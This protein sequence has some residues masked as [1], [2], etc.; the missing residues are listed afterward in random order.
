MNLSEHAICE[1]LSGRLPSGRL[2]ACFESDAE[3]IVLNGGKCLFT[4]DEF[5]EED[6]FGEGDARLLGWNIAVGAISD[7]YACGGQPL[8]YAHAL[9]VDEKWDGRYVSGF[10]E[11]VR[12]ALEATGARF[13]GGD[14]GRA[15]LWRCTVSVLGLCEGAPVLR[16]GA[17]PG[18][19]IYLTGPIGGGNLEAAL[20]LA[21]GQAG[22]GAPGPDWV[23]RL[24]VRREE[25][26]L[27]KGFASACIDTSDGVW[28]G[29]NAL[30]DL[31]GCGYALAN[32]PYLPAGLDFSAR[33]SLPRGLLFLGECG[34]YEL[35]FTVRPEREAA[36]VVAAREAGCEPHRL[37]RM[38]AGERTLSEAGR[39]LDLASLRIQARDYATPQ[40]YPRDAPG[41]AGAR[42]GAAASSEP[43]EELNMARRV[44]I[45]GLGPVTSVGI[46]AAAFFKALW[47]REFP[48]Q[49]IPPEFTR[50]YPFHSK[51]RVPQPE[52]SLSDYQIESAQESIMHPED[53]MAVLGA[54]LALEDAG[55]RLMSR[56]GRMGVRG[57]PGVRR[58]PGHGLQQPRERHSRCT[59]AT[60]CRARSLRPRSRS[61]R[62]CSAGWSS[63][64]PCPTRRRPGRR[65]VS[66]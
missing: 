5:S 13:I 31:N 27:I 16:R 1:L 55:Y 39:T 49:P 53:R 42:P 35:L 18:D 41:L 10:G 40:E 8:Y 25:S 37:G 6:R 57:A 15:K 46:G 56:G 34:E 32:L 4:M 7:I 62:R 52:V 19:G 61:A 20:R 14:C 48:G 63:P 30:G 54:K 45:T 59:S 12:D 43:R 22:A 66:G 64:R 3:V 2:N 29:L 65:L 36:L 58:H 47:N 33:A 38:T 9:T 23:L 51:W 28:A 26:M 17:A 21:Q 11:G 24:P 44:V 60:A 50:C